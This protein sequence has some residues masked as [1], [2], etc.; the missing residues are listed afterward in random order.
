MACIKAGMKS[1]L[2]HP[3]LGAP[4]TPLDDPDVP[5]T[6]GTRGGFPKG[7]SASHSNPT[8]AGPSLICVPGVPGPPLL[9]WPL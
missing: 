7:M 6:D 1:L 5:P 4:Q 8:T 2:P 9:S 3:T